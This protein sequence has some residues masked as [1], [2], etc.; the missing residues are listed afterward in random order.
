MKVQTQLLIVVALIAGLS[1][2]PIAQRRPTS[3][4]RSTSQSSTLTIKTEPNAII[5]I[6]EIRRG[7]TNASGQ[8]LVTKLSAGSHVLRTRATGFKETSIPLLPGRS[9]VTVK[10]VRTTDEAELKFQ[11]AEAAHEKAKDD[12]ARQHAV[13]LYRESV[14]LRPSYAAAH[15]GLARTLLEL[16]QN[17]KALDEIEAA[18][19]T[20]PVYAEASAVE[21]R[22]YKEMAFADEAAKSFQRAIREANG[23][24]PEA[25]VG[26]ARVYE[27]RGQYETAA[28]EY[29]L[30]IKQLSDSEP[31]IYQLLGA[32]YERLEKYKEAVGAYEKYLKLAP[33]G[34]LAPA[35][36]SII[37]QV[38]R[39]AA[40]RDIV[41]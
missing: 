26:L 12:E 18:R 7:T 32:T 28:T 35:I 5:W 4:R 14:K 23:F 11:E 2:N 33:N 25:H 22:I 21:G 39:E 3:N 9:Q 1:A 20:R 37:D 8:L 41:P 19:R 16:N 24:Q 36:R 34:N 6:D 13:E 30:A 29:E 15:L 31:V 17:E 40:G 27:D 10:L 38:R